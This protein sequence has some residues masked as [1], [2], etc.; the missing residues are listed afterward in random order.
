MKR[1]LL[2][3]EAGADGGSIKLIKINNLYFYTTDEST[4][5]DIDPTLTLE[6]L[7]SKSDAFP[8]FSEAMKGML[9]RYPIFGLYPL[10]VNANYKAR[11]VPYFQGYCCGNGKK[12]NWNKDSW[13]KMLYFRIEEFLKY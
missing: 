7:Q 13:E 2:I 8:S 5:R 6:E 12:E 11:L 3:L 10:T 4:L 1:K 9:E